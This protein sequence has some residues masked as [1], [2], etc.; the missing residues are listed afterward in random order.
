MAAVSLAST[1]KHRWVYSEGPVMTE[2]LYFEPDA[3]DTIAASSDSVRSSLSAAMEIGSPIAGGLDATI[4]VARFTSAT[5]GGANE[6]LR[7]ADMKTGSTVEGKP[8][9]III[10]GK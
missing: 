1:L 3:G 4:Q 8:F 10:T 9:V 6:G 2:V 5:A 7:V